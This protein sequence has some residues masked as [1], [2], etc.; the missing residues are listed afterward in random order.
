MR[1]SNPEIT[2]AV[3]KEP[4]A[5]VKKLTQN[6]AEQEIILAIVKQA[7]LSVSTVTA[8][9]NLLKFKTQEYIEYICMKKVSDMYKSKAKEGGV[10]RQIFVNAQIG[11]AE[12]ELHR[13]IRNASEG[14][15]LDV[16]GKIAETRERHA[17]HKASARPTSAPSAGTD[18][19][20]TEISVRDPAPPISL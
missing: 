9:S 8:Q 12:I 14:T 18:S 5:F 2:T 16:A 7:D 11:I 13:A 1:P 17:P 4:I 10:A 15:S 19:I 20:D 6:K 3:D